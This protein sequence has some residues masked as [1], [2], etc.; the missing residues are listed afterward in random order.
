[1]IKTIDLT[2]RLSTYNKDSEYD[3]IYYKPFPN[4]K[5]MDLAEIMVLNKLDEY[6]EKGN[7]DRFILPAGENIKLFT[8][9]IDKA[10]EYFN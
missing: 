1:M 10:Y 6:R 3:V 9:T 2:K 5:I 4:E 7:R 8:N